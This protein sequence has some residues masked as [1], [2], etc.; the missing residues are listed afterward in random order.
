[1][2]YLQLYVISFITWQYTRETHTDEQ[3]KPKKDIQWR[4]FKTQKFGIKQK[5]N[6][7]CTASTSFS[8]L[9]IF[10]ECQKL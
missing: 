3:T 4:C 8:S 2:S 5:I 10:A 7:K 9:Q 6:K 1:M